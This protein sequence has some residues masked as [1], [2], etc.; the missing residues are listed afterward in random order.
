MATLKRFADGRSSR[1]WSVAFVAL[2][3]VAGAVGFGL[4]QRDPAPESLVFV[5]V[6]AEVGL[7]VS[8][9]AFRWEMAMDPVAM[10]GGGLCW[11]DANN[12]GWL[13]LF[14]TDTWSN[15]E[16]GKW[17]E[18]GAL[19][20]S[21]LFLNDTGR[22]TDVSES[23][24]VDYE[25]RANGCVAADLNGDGFSDLYVT[26]E[27]ENLLLW[28]QKGSGFVNG[29]EAA[30]VEAYGWA[31]GV[32][33]GDIDGD[34]RTDLVVAGYADLNRSIDDA[35]TGFPNMFEPIDDWIFMNAGGAERPAFEEI[36]AGLEPDGPE[37]GLGTVLA[38]FDSDGD[39]DLYIANDTQPNRLYRNDSTPGVAKLVDVSAEMGVDD[40]NSGMGIAAADV[41]GD[42][43]SDLVVTNLAGQRHA[44]F[45]RTPD[46][47]YLPAF[48]AVRDV[49]M[50]ATGWGTSFG[51]FDNDGDQDL[52][53]AS[54]AIP[55]VSLSESSEPV[56]FL[57]NDDGVF[58]DGSTA[59]AIDELAD[60][61]GRSIAVADFD[62]DGDLDAAVSAI[63]QP[64]VLIENRV[65]GGD[66][67]MIDPGVPM[68]GLKV[69]V[70]ATSGSVVEAVHHV[71]GSWLSSEDP[72][73][74]VGL[75]ADD[76]IALVEVW[77]PDGT[78]LYEGIAEANRVLNVHQ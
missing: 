77:A 45:Q 13:D 47:G 33:A 58:I 15:G 63:G 7:D 32:A 78:V 38:D 4:L 14:V 76:P 40:P 31:T 5:D 74:H 41:D 27:R 54:G 55:I 75:R 21:K 24:G 69:R 29:A 57:R 49:G 37:Y 52:L 65:V 70:T 34:G 28:N 61:N 48:G 44:A 17:T 46:G 56:T 10:M 59:V 72:R 60:R 11:I 50:D 23:W 26:T 1:L 62:N 2:A 16:W 18:A 36:D 73:I 8:H 6:A 19:P 67:I 43:F 30:G 3:I 51:D 39:L 64:L 25:V 20:T 68:P 42:Q 22:F 66:W 9:S 35:Q 53:V 12:D 71:G